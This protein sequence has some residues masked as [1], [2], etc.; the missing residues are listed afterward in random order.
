MLSH[1]LGPCGVSPSRMLLHDARAHST[2]ATLTSNDAQMDFIGHRN[3]QAIAKLHEAV[4]LRS[5]AACVTLGKCVFSR[6]ALLSV[7]SRPLAPLGRAR[8]REDTLSTH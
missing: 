4:A 2:I 7:R 6:R 5:S 8:P 3:S 1:A